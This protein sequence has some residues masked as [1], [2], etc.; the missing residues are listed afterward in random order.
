MLAKSNIELTEI[1]ND[2]ID[3]NNKKVNLYNNI[4]LQ[5]GSMEYMNVW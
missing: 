1:L 2:I 4:Q 5:Y 3:K